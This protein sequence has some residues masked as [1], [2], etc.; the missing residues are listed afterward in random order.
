MVEDESL[1]SH[2]WNYRDEAF[3]GTVSRLARRRGG[4]K[5]ARSMSLRVLNNFRIREP[6]PR[7][8]DETK[9]NKQ[10]QHA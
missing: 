2:Y 6:I 4:R 9:K 10:Q 1:P 5:T 7:I 3:G 8:V